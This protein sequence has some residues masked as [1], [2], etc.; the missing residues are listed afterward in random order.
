MG[1]GTQT[2]LERLDNS[3]WLLL[4]GQ[5]SSSSRVP[6]PHFIAEFGHGSFSFFRSA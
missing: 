2:W 5:S 4:G 6:P 1:M 3:P